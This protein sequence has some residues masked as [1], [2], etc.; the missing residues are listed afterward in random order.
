METAAYELYNALDD[1]TG[2]VDLI[3]WGGSNRWLPVVYFWLFARAVLRV[4]ARRPD[5]ILL[6]DGVMAPLGW[7]LKV[8]S[9]RPTLIVIHGLEVTLQNR[10]YRRLVLPFIKR[11]TALAAVSEATRSAITAATGL[12]SERVEVIRNGIRDVFYSSAPRCEQL[13]LI[14]SAAGIPLWSLEHSHVLVTTGRLVKRK[15]VS[16]FI[17]NAMPKIVADDPH[18]LYLVA[19][20]GPQEAEIALAIKR[21]NLADNVKLLGEV[22]QE[23]LKALYN[24]ADIF[25]MPNM[26]VPNNIE[27]FGLVAIEAASCGATVVAS[28][29]DGISDAV[30]SGENGYLVPAGDASAYAG[31]IARELARPSQS[32][33][34]V[35][36]YTLGHYS[37]TES[38]RAYRSLARSIASKDAERSGSSGEVIGSTDLPDRPGRRD[39]H[40]FPLTGVVRQR[41]A[42]SARN[43]GRS[44]SSADK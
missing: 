38:A 36:Q 4:L 2:K 24:A 15:G 13:A 27:G 9:G 34:A 21:G 17:D 3:A 37:W 14:A 29:L 12:G 30:V 20:S 39:E 23:C 6:Q 35:R 22:S 16:W 5:V 11:Q 1:G 40:A 18:I 10:V 25:V 33:A 19:G 26:C 41:N 44:L 7:A 43:E 8:L 28:D 31:V 42:S 32:P